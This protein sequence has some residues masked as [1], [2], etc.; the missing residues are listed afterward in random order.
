MQINWKIFFT[1]QPRQHQLRD[2]GTREK[3]LLDLEQDAAQADS[4]RGDL[5]PVRHP[6]R[7]QAA[8]VSVGENPMLADL[9]HDHRHLHPQARPAARLDFD[10]Q[11]QR[12]LIIGKVNIY[13]S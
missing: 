1:A 13:Q 8:A 11:G 5:R 10:A 3:R 4:F 2:F 6:H 12:L 7:L 9:L